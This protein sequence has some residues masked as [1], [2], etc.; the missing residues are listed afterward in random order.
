MGT[1]PPDQHIVPGEQNHNMTALSD[2][3]FDQLRAAFIAEAS[4]VL[5]FRYFAQISEIE[6]SLDTARLFTDLAESAACVAHG[7][8]DFLQTVADPATGRPMGDTDLN[9]AAAVS[10]E[11]DAATVRYPAL[12]QEAH[13]EGLADVASWLETLC[14]LK[15]AHLARLTAA[16]EALRGGPQ[17][18]QL[19]TAVAE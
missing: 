7:H 9:L 4:T 6:G 16:H 11:I 12:A 18:T 14:A 5:R 15:H 2:G 13:N 1:R 17:T 10:S 3:F 19:D 8:L